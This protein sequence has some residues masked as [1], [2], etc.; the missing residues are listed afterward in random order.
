MTSTGTKVLT[1]RNIHKY[2]PGVHALKGVDLELHEG[3][4]LALV[5]ENGAG[6]STLIKT[7][8]GA[9]RPSSGTIELYGEQVD[10]SNP[11]EAQKLGIGIIYQEF[12]LVPYLT[13]RENIFLGNEITRG[14]L[15]DKQGERVKAAQLLAKIGIKIDPETVCQSLSVAQQQIVEIA[16]AL[17]QNVRILVMDEPSATLTPQE[18]GGLFDIIKDLKKQG[19]GVIY[20]SHRL[21]EIFEIC[22]RVIVLRDG[23]SVG[24]HDIVDISRQEM[25]ELMVGRK[26]ENE[27][28]KH[29]HP[30][31]KVRLQVDQ[32]CRSEAIKNV[33]F[34]LKAGEVLGITGLIGAGRTELMRL[35]F[36]AD[37]LDSGTMTKDGCRI[38]FGSPIDAIKNG[39]GLLTEDRKLEGLILKHSAR[40]NFGLPNLDQFSWHQILRP[41]QEHLSFQKLATQVKLKLPS[42]TQQAG[43]LSGG[44]QQKLVLIKWLQRNCDIIIF[45]EPTRGIDVGAKYE[46]YLLINQLA[47]QGKGIIMVSSELPEI[48]GMSDRILV[49][50][51]GE[52]TGEV[53]D[54]ANATQEQLIQYA[55]HE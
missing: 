16:K 28:P 54:V 23:E 29:H 11:Y 42:A 6:K 46:I 15:I 25:I 19:I 5:G 2:F 13:A 4:V 32:L 26:I 17:A 12:N 43:N 10:I 49:M 30:I 44:N 45:D 38:S 36:G 27:F 1:M 7:L 40:S 3:E 41:K 8:G 24:D 47:S 55:I 9:H 48:L 35:I 50:R 22:D 31:G 18:V 33:S 21:S 34:Q 52:I 37:P 53:R 51:N 20:I 39:I 14:I